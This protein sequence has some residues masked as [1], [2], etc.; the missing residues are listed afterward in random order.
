[1]KASKSGKTAPRM[2]ANA[3]PHVGSLERARYARVGIEAC[4]RGSMAKALNYGASKS[5]R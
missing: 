3:P 5:F 4:S 2:R 1:V